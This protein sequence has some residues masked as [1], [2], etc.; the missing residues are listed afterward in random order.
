MDN[1]LIM[2]IGV[3]S[4][5]MVAGLIFGPAT[6]RL[7]CRYVDGFIDGYRQA[8]QLSRNRGDAS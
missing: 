1:L 3:F 2:L 4:A 8:S 6:E 5:G 7:D